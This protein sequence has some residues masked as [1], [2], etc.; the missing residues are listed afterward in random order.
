[1]NREHVTKDLTHKKQRG[2]DVDCGPRPCSI[3]QQPEQEEAQ[4]SGDGQHDGLAA[5]TAP[6]KPS[7]IAATN[8]IARI[9]F[10]DVLL[11]SLNQL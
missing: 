6:A 5:F 3:A 4:H 11:F 9:L 1:M 8:R 2:A 7:A 10:I